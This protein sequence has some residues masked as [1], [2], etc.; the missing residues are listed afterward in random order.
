M[1]ISKLIFFP[2]NPDHLV[3]NR[4]IINTLISAEFINAET[5]NN[6]HYL[7]GE[8]FL[9]LITFLGCSPNINLFPVENET[10]CFISLLEQTSEAQCLGYTSTV[11]PKCPNCKKRIADWKTENWNKAGEICS[12]DKCNTQ[13]PYAELNWKHEC[14]FSRGGFEIA[15][16]YP[17]EAVPTEQLLNKLEKATSFKWNYCY[18]IN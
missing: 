14:G 5:H 13:T 3:E 8:K 15:H 18:A 1:P 2:E 7:P 10:H 11:N 4:L 9:S 6:N 16:I 12:C 17:H